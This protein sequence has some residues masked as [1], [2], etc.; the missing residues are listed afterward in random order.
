V[1][2]PCPWWRRWWHRRQ[3]R[4]DR[5]VIW[6]ALRARAAA[7]YPDDEEAAVLSALRGWAVFIQLPGQAHWACACNEGRDEAQ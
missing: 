2:A 6:P 5:A 4:L 3:R 7:R 1:G